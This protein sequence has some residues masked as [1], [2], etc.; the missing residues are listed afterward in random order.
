MTADADCSVGSLTATSQRRVA[1]SNGPTSLLASLVAELSTAAK[2]DLL[3][4]VVVTAAAAVAVDILATEEGN[5]EYDRRFVS[6]DAMFPRPPDM[7]PSFSGENMELFKLSSPKVLTEF[8][9]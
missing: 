2:H 9:G 8:I 4:T 6:T 1:I 7:P 5:V 3:S